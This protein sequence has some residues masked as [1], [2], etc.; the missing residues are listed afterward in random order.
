MLIFCTLRVLEVRRHSAQVLEYDRSMCTMDNRHDQL[1]K[2][3]GDYM[4]GWSRDNLLSG[5]STFLS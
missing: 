2:D 4:Y 5:V 1:T 3:E